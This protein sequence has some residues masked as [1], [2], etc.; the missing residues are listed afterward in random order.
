[1]RRAPADR[2]VT[3]SASTCVRPLSAATLWHH[4]ARVDVPRYDRDA[5]RPGV[6]HISVGSFH[7]AHQAVYFDDLARAGDRDWG[8]TGVSVRRPVVQEALAAQDGLYTV[9]TRGTDGATARV[10]GALRRCL[11]SPRD[12]DAVMRALTHPRTRLVTLTITADGY[13]LAA[14]GD[15]LRTGDPEL[16]ADRADPRRP[17]SALGHLVEALA[18]RRR[19]G[20]APFTVLSCD[21][22]PRNGA[23]TRTAVVAAARLRDPDL[24]AWIEATGAFP[25]SMVDRITPRASVADH[26]VLQRDFGVADRCPVVTEPFCQWVVEDAF[27]CGRPPLDAVG[28][29][30]VGDVAPYALWKTRLLNAAHCAIGHLGGL[31]GHTTTAGAMAD[32]VLRSHVEALFDEVTPLLPPLP[33]AAAG[34]YAR[35]VIDRLRNPAIGDRLSRLRRNGSDKVPAHV[36]SSL[37]EARAAGRPHDALLLAA[38]AWLATLQGED[39]RGEPLGLDDPRGDELRMRAWRAGADPRPFTTDRTLF[40]PLAGDPHL[41][42]DLA[43]T[44]AAL[45]RH[46]ARAVAAGLDQGVPS[47]G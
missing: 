31:A 9:L 10:V 38:A 16:Q 18:R 33:G 3:T 22:I 23:L 42:D 17:T 46:G 41:A 2:V 34:T 27:S 37:H 28:V 36:L 12:G 35:A 45:R 21:N 30:F 15:G 32:P 7:R 8:L 43:A 4:A 25:S 29:Q 1:V 39:D 6:V 20:L 40:G 14:G 5:L 24:A 19:A 11:H 44:M 47:V 26:R 13:K